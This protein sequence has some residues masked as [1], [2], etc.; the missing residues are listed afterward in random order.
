MS[1]FR[2]KNNK[3]VTSKYSGLKVVFCIPGNSFSGAFLSCWSNLVKV[4]SSYNI[5]WELI[6]GYQPNIY[7]VRNELAGLAL[8]NDLDKIMW[9]DSDI[10]FSPNDFLKLLDCNVDIISGLYIVQ[11]ENQRKMNM[12]Q[13]RTQSRGD[14]YYAAISEA[15]SF[16]KV[17]DVKSL[18][19][20]TVKSNGMGF[21]LMN[22]KVLTSIGD[23]WFNPIN[24]REII[25]EDISFQIKARE[26]GYKSYV[27]PKVVVGHEKGITLI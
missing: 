10:V 9:I 25:S 4:M 7:N 5:D 16:L 12:S 3:I 27:N 1:W 11:M 19:I 26:L 2:N 13:I 15:G 24:N 8:K 20:F 21:M 23:R 17:S 6:R 22:K 14:Y 18:D